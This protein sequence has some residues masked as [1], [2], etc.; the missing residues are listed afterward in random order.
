[1]AALAGMIGGIFRGCTPPHAPV[2]KGKS[3]SELVVDWD[4]DEDEGVAYYEVEVAGPID[5]DDDDAT[6]PSEWQSRVKKHGHTG[7]PHGKRAVITDCEPDSYYK[8]RVAAVNISGYRATGTCGATTSSG[9][10]TDDATPIDNNVENRHELHVYNALIVSE[11]VY[12]DNPQLYMRSITRKHSLNMDFILDDRVTLFSTKDKKSC[13]VAF[14]GPHTPFYSEPVQED[15]LRRILQIVREKGTFSDVYFVGFDNGGTSATTSLLAVLSSGIA[16]DV[17][18]GCIT[19]GA[20]IFLAVDEPVCL[21]HHLLFYHVVHARDPVPFQPLTM[22]PDWGTDFNTT[23]RTCRCTNEHFMDVPLSWVDGMWGVKRNAVVNRMHSLNNELGLRKDSLHEDP[24]A[25]LPLGT[26]KIIGG[27]YDNVATTNIMEYV[28]SCPQF[29]IADLECHIPLHYAKAVNPPRGDCDEDTMFHNVSLKLG[30]EISSEFTYVS[31]YGNTIEAVIY[32]KNLRYARGVTLNIEGTR[33]CNLSIVEA[34]MHKLRAN[35][36]VAEVGLV[37]N[38]MDLELEVISEHAARVVCDG[39][40]CVEYTNLRAVPAWASHFANMPLAELF[41]SALRFSLLRSDSGWTCCRLHKPMYS[42]KDVTEFINEH[43]KQW[44]RRV[45]VLPMRELD[46]V[47]TNEIRDLYDETLLGCVCDEDLYKSVRDHALETNKALHSEIKLA[48][49]GIRSDASS[50]ALFMTKVT[51]AVGGVAVLMTPPGQIAAATALPVLATTVSA[52]CIDTMQ[53][54][55]SCLATYVDKLRFLIQTLGMQCDKVPAEAYYYELLLH[56]K[57]AEYL[58]KTDMGG[59]MAEYEAAAMAKWESIFPDDEND[60]HHWMWYCNKEDKKTFVRLLWSVEQ[61]FSIRTTMTELFVVQVF[62]QTDAGKTTVVKNVFG[63]S[64]AQPGSMVKDVTM[65]KSGY[66]VDFS[67][68]L[69]V[70]DNPGIVDSKGR[71]EVLLTNAAYYIVVVNWDGGMRAVP[72]ILRMAEIQASGVPFK[73]IIT[74]CDQMVMGGWKR[75]EIDEWLVGHITL[76][77]DILNDCRRHL[78]QE[79]GVDIADSLKEGLANAAAFKVADLG[80]STERIGREKITQDQCILSC[81]SAVDDFEISVLRES[82][83]RKEGI[84]MVTDVRDALSQDWADL[85]FSVSFPASSAQD[86][87]PR[88]EDSAEVA[89]TDDDIL[90]AARTDA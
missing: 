85:D 69:V 20:P 77:N 87:S 41:S 31:V 43:N 89:T 50:W 27:G 64:Q 51:A 19:F 25:I 88:V 42:L 75:R 16:L 53:H 61:V 2:L 28:K 21:E 32:G 48:L 23:T 79:D 39:V 44:M 29:T 68:N 83:C 15:V 60:A 80:L 14:K 10:K 67:N 1:M 49:S 86:V 56:G 70:V 22:N 3:S 33:S 12:T 82:K 30:P 45:M 84:A 62:G 55:V 78:A 4:C 9:F 38:T 34:H 59:S 11:A 46:I 54:V 47:T 18:M 6:F 63:V 37:N 7:R 72:F 26:V 36:T 90:R 76:L 71:G 35:I 57:M 81:I 13:Y 65:R 24:G 66:H 58:S 40:R 74:K 17:F 73:L 8:V 5:S 52:Q